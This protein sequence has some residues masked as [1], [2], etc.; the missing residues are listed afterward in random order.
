I[1]RVSTAFHKRLCLSGLDIENGDVS[2]VEGFGVGRSHGE[3]NRF[4]AGQCARIPMLTFAFCE[5]DFGNF[6]WLPAGR[7]DARESPGNDRNEI[8]RVISRPCSPD[9]T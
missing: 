7:R 2:V 3:Q 6:Y 1:A 5:V 8:N 9:E 4:S